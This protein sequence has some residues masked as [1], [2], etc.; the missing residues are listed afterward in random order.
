MS[1]RRQTAHRRRVERVLER[2]LQDRRREVAATLHGFRDTLPA[3]APAAKDVD[4]HAVEDL[5]RDLEFA[6]AQMRTA[7]LQRIDD[8]IRRLRDGTYGICT[9]CGADIAQ[10][11]LEALPFASLC[12]YCQAE[13]EITEQPGSP[14]ESDWTSHSRVS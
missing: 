3:E 14:L 8:A 1:N 6:L 4:D 11:R 10:A 9:D 13:R 12:R 2:L 7:T 5:T